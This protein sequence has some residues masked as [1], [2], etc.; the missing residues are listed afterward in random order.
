VDLS[1]GDGNLRAILSGDTILLAGLAEEG[2]A[3]GEND[4]GHGREP[5]NVRGCASIFISQ[6]RRITNFPSR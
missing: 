2:A 4:A 3:V 6:M 5:Q 1:G